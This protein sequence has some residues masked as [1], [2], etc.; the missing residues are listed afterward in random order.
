MTPLVSGAAALVLGLVGGRLLG[1]GVRRLLAWE[2][3]GRPSRWRTDWLTPAVAACAAIALWWWEVAA[4]GLLPEGVAEPEREALVRA[5]AHGVLG[6]LLAAA[7]WI[8]LRHRV[9]P[10]AITVPG[11]L[12]GLAWVTAWPRSLLPVAREVKKGSKLCGSASAGIPLPRSSTSMTTL[13]ASPH[14]RSAICPPCGIAAAPL[15]TRFSRASS[16]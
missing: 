9:I 6:L 1:L 14:A 8:D 12:G 3:D 16:S 2:G 13:S 5:A 11:V 4:R 7:T 10:D 15:R